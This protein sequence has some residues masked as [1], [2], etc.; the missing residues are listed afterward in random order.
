VEPRPAVRSAAIPHVAA[1]AVYGSISIL[2]FGSRLAGHG[3]GLVGHGVDADLFTWMLGWWPHALL[4]GEN[5]FLPHII[6][7]PSGVNLAWATS[8]P[9]LALPVAPITLLFGPA[10]AYNTL[11]L[12]LPA[13][14][15]WTAYLLCHHLT[16][17]FWPSL[18][19][20]YLFGF[21]SY[22]LGQERGH[23]HLTSVFLIPLVALLMI[24]FLQQSVRRRSFVVLLGVTIAWELTLSTEVALTM[25]FA[26][27]VCLAIAYGLIPD[28]R[29]RLRALGGPLVFA[30]LFGAVLAAPLLVY[31]LK[32]HQPIGN[33]PA[34]A[35]GDL[36][37]IVSPTKLTWLHTSWSRRMAAN[38]RANTTESG[39]YVGLPLLVIV[40]WFSWSQ[41]RKRENLF[42]TIAL[43]AG[44]FCSL[45]TELDVAGTRYTWLPWNA[46]AHQP[47]FNHVL[48][49]RFSLYTA[50]A[51]AVIAALWAASPAIPKVARAILVSVA[52]FV[53]VPN[54]ALSR[55]WYEHPARPAF[56]TSG[57]FKRCF[58]ARDNILMLPSPGRR[59][60]AMLWQAEAMYSFRMA[61]GWIT[62]V[63]PRTIPRHKTMTR[64]FTGRKS[65]TAGQLAEWAR[66]DGVTL[67]AVDS[68]H[69]PQWRHLLARVAHPQE[70]GGVYLYRLEPRGSV[71][72][73][74]V[75][76]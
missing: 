65:L 19:G 8:V 41:R 76:G 43:A 32:N 10:A 53:L 23:L 12:L 44:L 60:A 39:L 14:A 28:F 35:S 34:H 6:W 7:A 21:S 2:Y 40:L 17:M 11:A 1:L 71:P 66:A 64:F 52:V 31:V 46:I 49:A 9:G 16:R 30:Y 72:C 20:G 3:G 55:A 27:A 38:F 74:S 63:P 50:L 75:V 26:L 36:L 29:G 24:R 22:M 56:F 5:P 18:A 73:A 13:L 48:P 37:N 45:G 59:S 4:H 15:A 61:D 33:P 62:A 67:I 25:T 51:A 47:L 57:A 68:A 69:E 54:V 70:I 42:L 58:T